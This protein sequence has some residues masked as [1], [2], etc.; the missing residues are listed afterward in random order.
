MT[1]PKRQRAERKE[2]DAALRS[3]RAWRMYAYGMMVFA[4]VLLVAFALLVLHPRRKDSGWRTDVPP[5]RQKLEVV[6]SAWWCPK[7]GW[8]N[9]EDGMPVTVKSWRP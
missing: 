2:V 8:C 7:R 4:G 9:Y 5:A 6:V 3:A 1:Q